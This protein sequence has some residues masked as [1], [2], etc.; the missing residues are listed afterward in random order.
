MDRFEKITNIENLQLLEK[1]LKKILEDTKTNSEKTSD[2]V[3]F[4]KLLKDTQKDLEK[5][6]NS[7]LPILICTNQTE[8]AIHFVYYLGDLDRIR[9]TDELLPNTIDLQSKLN[10]S[11]NISKIISTQEYLN[12]L[13]NDILK[14]SNVDNW[15]EVSF[16]LEK[17]LNEKQIKKRLENNY[18][19]NC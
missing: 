17:E 11:Y 2:S 15:I 14:T 6:L 9:V 1:N 12:S 10:C 13:I 4:Q 8:E 7:D 19:R 3:V 5:A 18:A 16:L